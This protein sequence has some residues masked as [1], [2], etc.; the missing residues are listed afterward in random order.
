[1]PAD[2]FAT[3][4]RGKNSIDRK[5]VSPLRKRLI[6]NLD[7]LGITLD[8]IE[9]MTFG[10]DYADGSN[11]LILDSDTNFSDPQFTQFLA[12]RLYVNH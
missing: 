8:N 10:P 2:G 11:S 7:Q 4:V 9:G 1:M 6:L 12:F 5:H 3:N